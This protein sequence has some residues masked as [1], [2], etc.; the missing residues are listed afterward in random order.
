MVNQNDH[1]GKDVLIMTRKKFVLKAALI[2]SMFSSFGVFVVA[3]ELNTTKSDAKIGIETKTLVEGTTY[4]MTSGT[5]N[6]YDKDHV[7][8]THGQ[9]NYGYYYAIYIKTATGT[10]LNSKDVNN[11]ASATIQYADPHDKYLSH[12]HMAVG[13]LMQ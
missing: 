9:G 11:R 5:A 13:S 6:A 7:Y 8:Y 4:R 10:I 12:Y 1:K 3:N 2:L